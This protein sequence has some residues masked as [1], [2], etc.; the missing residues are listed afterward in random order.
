M[1]IGGR[2]TRGALGVLALFALT[3][4]VASF[5][6]FGPMAANA[7]FARAPAHPFNRPDAASIFIVTPMA[8]AGLATLLLVFFTD[9]IA[10]FLGTGLA[11]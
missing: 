10:Q 7:L 1:R 9:T 4:A 2:F 6:A 3:C 8:L 5:A 11:P